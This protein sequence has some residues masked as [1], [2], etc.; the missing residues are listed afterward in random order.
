MNAVTKDGV[1]YEKRVTTNDVWRFWFDATGKGKDADF[2]AHNTFLEHIVEYYLQHHADL[3][4]TKINTWTD[5][6]AGCG[7][8]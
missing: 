8:V 3:K 4:I 5:Q 2:L 1:Q 6:C 7:C